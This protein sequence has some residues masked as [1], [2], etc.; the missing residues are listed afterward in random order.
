MTGR[1]F[2]APVRLRGA[3]A[4]ANQ[5]LLSFDGLTGV[6]FVIDASA[7]LRSW[8]PVHTNSVVNGHFEWVDNQSLSRRFYRARQQ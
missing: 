8:T 4:G 1:R 2:A 7:D 5:F 6:R 3:P